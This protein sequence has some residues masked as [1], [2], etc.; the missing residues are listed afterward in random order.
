MLASAN[1]PPSFIWHGGHKTYARQPS[2][3]TEFLGMR[4]PGVSQVS[5]SNVPI[6]QPKDI[7]VFCDGTGKDG[8]LDT[9]QPSLH[10]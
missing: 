10:F 8:R 1:T 3:L 6:N 5:A 4:Q 2:S 9:G 7:M